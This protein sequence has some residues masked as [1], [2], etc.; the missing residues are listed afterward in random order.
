M[1][2]IISFGGPDHFAKMMTVISRSRSAKGRFGFIDL[3]IQCED[4]P[5]KIIVQPQLPDK[6][7]GKAGVGSTYWIMHA[8]IRKI[9]ARLVLLIIAFSFCK[10]SRCIET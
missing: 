5:V 10:E 9:L 6:I 2:E 3:E 4:S 1:R 8:I 7:C